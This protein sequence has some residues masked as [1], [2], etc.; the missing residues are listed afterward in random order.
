MCEATVKHVLKLW[1]QALE[2][3]CANNNN[4]SADDF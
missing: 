1:K 4:N 3:S 2:L